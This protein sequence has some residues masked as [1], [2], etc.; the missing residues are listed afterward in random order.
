MSY[1]LRFGRSSST[2]SMAYKSVHPVVHQPP[3]TPSKATEKKQL[4]L[5]DVMAELKHIK[6]TL[7][8]VSTSVGSLENS[9]EKAFTEI[10]A[11]K[12]DLEHVN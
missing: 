11:V 4:T 12:D 6:T 3:A 2:S 9:V 7:S 5:E 10:K 8:T 1:N